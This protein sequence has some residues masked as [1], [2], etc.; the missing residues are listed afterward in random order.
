MEYTF[1]VNDVADPAPQVLMTYDEEDNYK[2]AYAYG[3]ERIKVQEL[4]D[5]R[6]ETQDPLH[7]LYDGLGSVKQLIRPNGAVRDHYNYDEYGVTCT[8]REVV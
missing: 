7:Y 5:T 3:L 2:A 6:S 1:Y 8:G 4:D